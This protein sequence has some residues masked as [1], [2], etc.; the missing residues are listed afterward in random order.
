[1]LKIDRNE[2]T[3]LPLSFIGP[4]SSVFQSDTAY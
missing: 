2:T 4:L 3:S 1:M